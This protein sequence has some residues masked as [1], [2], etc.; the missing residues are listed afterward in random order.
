MW[1][2]EPPSAIADRVMFTPTCAQQHTLGDTISIF[3]SIGLPGERGLGFGVSV[4]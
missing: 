3:P 1:T 2:D 4:A